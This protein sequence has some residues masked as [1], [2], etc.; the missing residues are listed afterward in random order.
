M[1]IVIMVI[2]VM[3]IMGIL[4]IMGILMGIYFHH[5]VD[6]SKGN[7]NTIT[8]H[9]S[10]IINSNFNTITQITQITIIAIRT[11]RTIES[12]SVNLEWMSLS[13]QHYPSTNIIKNNNNNNSNNTTYII[14]TTI[15]TIMILLLVH[16]LLFSLISYSTWNKNTN[17]SYRHTR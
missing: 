8:V 3:A 6:I 10:S 17:P 4:I 1:V 15:I 9:S 5:Q 7:N 14:A 11:I 12:Q 13:N 16:N 2:I